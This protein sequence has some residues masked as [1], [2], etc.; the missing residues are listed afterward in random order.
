[1]GP[2]GADRT[3]AGS[4]RRAASGPEAKAPV[5]KAKRAARTRTILLNKTARA[6]PRESEKCIIL[7]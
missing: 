5:A 4:E 7:L 6:M 3:M 1:V 2:L